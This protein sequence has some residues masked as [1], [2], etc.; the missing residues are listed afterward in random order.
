MNFN[1]I[2]N[3]AIK[4]VDVVYC[5]T[6]FYIGGLDFGVLLFYRIFLC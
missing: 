6:A 4:L 5:L 2:M 3:F 1:F